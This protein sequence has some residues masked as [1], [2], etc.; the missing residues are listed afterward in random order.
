MRKNSQLFMSRSVLAI[1]VASI[2]L[3][4]S[5]EWGSSDSDNDTTEESPYVTETAGDDAQQQETVDDATQPRGTVNEPEQQQEKR[6]ESS[7]V[8]PME[9][10]TVDD[11][12]EPI[13]FITFVDQAPVYPGGEEA[14]M[15]YINDNI[16]YPV[17]ATEEGIEGTVYVSFIIR[18][19]G[20]VDKVMVIKGIGG[21]CDEEAVRVVKGMPYWS[22]GYENGVPVKVEYH[23]PVIFSLF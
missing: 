20:K 4:A 7:D 11:V 6:V 10:E 22:P 17:I 15:R 3:F 1:I 19:N 5:C 8:E 23:L 18:K 13:V 2:F 16:E 9:D 14:L 12:A 21:G